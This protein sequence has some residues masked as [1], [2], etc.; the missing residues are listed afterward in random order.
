MKEKNVFLLIHVYL[1]S[2]T[3]RAGT[4]YPSGAPES[5]P[6]IFSGD[7]IAQ[8][9][10]LCGVLFCRSLFALF[11]LF[12]SIIVLSVPLQFPAS[13]FHFGIFKP[14]LFKIYIVTPSV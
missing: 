14:F 8:S 9:A 11:V 10:V 1:T 12:P 7:R 3:S 5:S 2:I 4:A 13:G 6:S